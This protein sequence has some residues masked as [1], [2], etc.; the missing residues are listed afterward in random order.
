MSNAQRRLIGWVAAFSVAACGDG[1]GPGGGT[2]TVRG[3][4]EQTAPAPANAASAA[5]TPAPAP[6]LGA[7]AETVAVVQVHANGGLSELATAAVSA[8]GTFV[9]EGVPAGREDL[10]VVAY[11]GGEA[12]G[13]VLVHERSRGGFVIHAAPIN[14]ETTVEAR[15]YSELRASGQTGVTASELSLLLHLHGSDAATVAGSAAELDA[16][17]AG[18]VVASSTLTEVYAAYGVSMDAAARAR[19]LQDAAVEFAASRH[20]GTSLGAAHAVFADAALEVLAAG[21]ASA[22]ASV[23]AWAAAASAFD[24]ALATGSSARE[25]VVAQSVLLNLRARERLAAE[26]ATTATA[27]IG[28]SIAAALS[29]GRL[30]LIAGGIIDLGVLVETTGAAAAAAVVDQ[31]VDVLAATASSS[32]RAEVRARAEAA[33]EAARLAARFEGAA[34][35]GEFRAALTGYEAAVRAAVDAMVAASGSSGV[36]ADAMANLF[37]AACGGAY[38]R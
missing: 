36:N 38:I 10:A 19:L 18:Y 29:A 31:S 28:A 9:V 20:E 37:I 27:S 1:M 16:V 4:V 5:S 3:R 21:G 32:V 13:S 24:A 34:T 8:D 33:V 12:V 26:V 14:H 11:A 6:G 15:A 2:A 7:G 23:M 30:E 17:A 25:A 35:P 22:D